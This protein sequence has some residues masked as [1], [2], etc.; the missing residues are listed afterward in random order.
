MSISGT[1][2]D[3]INL[4]I[5]KIIDGKSCL[6]WDDIID[7]KIINVVGYG[8]FEIYIN[9]KSDQNT[10]K[11]VVGYSLETELTQ[12]PLYDLHINDDDYFNYG[13]Q[14]ESNLDSYGNIKPIKLYNPSDPDHSLLHL[15]L[16]D[17]ACHWTLGVVPQYI[18]VTNNGRQE[19]ELATSFQRTFTI[20]GQNIYD[21]LVSD[22]ANEANLIYIFDTY[23]RRI[24][25]Y[26]RYAIGEDTNVF[27]NTRNLAE[28]IS[29]DDNADSVKNC[30][31]VVGGDDVVT[32]Y[33]AAINLTG[34]YIWGFHNFQ[35][36]DMPDG[37][38]N[39]IKSYQELKNEISDEYYG[40]Y[41]VLNKLLSDGQ[42]TDTI[43]TFD[44][45]VNSFTSLP[46][47]SGKTGHYY[48]INDTNK[49]YVSNGTS[50]VVCG[51]FTRLCSAYDYLSY[52][53]NSMMPNVSLKTTSAQEQAS[54][55]EREFVN[56]Q[57]AVNNLS[58]HSTASFT[59]VTNN[60]VA[61]CK[62]IIDNRY[63]VE[64]IDDIT[65]NYPRYSGNT[66]TGKIHIYRTADKN[67]TRTITLS[68]RINDDELNF[69]KQKIL[70]AVA[71]NEMAEVDQDV[72]AYTTSADYGKLV[73]YFQKYCLNRLKSFYDG[74]ETCLSILMSFQSSAKNSSA[75]NTI[76]TTY[77][78]RRDAVYEVY[79]IREGEVE[80]Q[81]Q[82]IDVIESE[83]NVIQ[84]QV[85]FKSYLDN[86]DPSYWRVF[87]SYRREDTY[88][89]DNYVSDGLT[90]GQILAK[91]K[92]LL[93]Y[94]AYQLSMVCQ[95]Q[96]TCSI[97]LSNL[98]IMDEFKP[99]WDKFQIYN[100]IRI[101][102]D[103]E[104]L[105]LRLAQVDVD[106]DAIEQLK[107]TFAENI[108]G[109][110]NIASDLS[111]IIK[112]TGFMASSY[113]SI[114]QQSS[115]GNKAF[116]Q[117]GKWIA[118][119]LNAAKTTIA[120]SD[121]NEV[122]FGSYGINLKDMTEEGNYGDFQTRLIGQGL[123]YTQDGWKTV[124]LA[125]GTI[126]IDGK[127]TSG[128]IAENLIGRLVACETLYLTNEKRSFLLSGD[129]A[130]FTD[131]TIDYQDK[132]GNRVKI[133]GTSDR[134][135]SISHNGNEVLYFNNVSNKMV[136][137]GTLQGCDGDFSGTLNACNMSASTITGST[138]NGNTINGN[139]ITGNTISSNNLIGNTITGGSIKIGN[140]F[141]VDTNGNMT[142]VDGTFTGTIK[143]GTAI[144]SPS[145]NGG[146]INGT[147][148]N[149][150]NNFIVDSSGNVT[151]NSG[152]FKG[153]IHA[154][155]GYFK[156]DLTGCSG[157][158]SDKVIGADVQAKTF[159]LWNP[160]SGKY[161][162]V[163]TAKNKTSWVYNNSG[164]NNPNVS[165]VCAN[166]LGT[167][168]FRDGYGKACID[169]NTLY[170]DNIY[171]QFALG[172]SSGTNGMRVYQMNGS[173]DNHGIPSAGWVKNFERIK[174]ISI[175]ENDYR[176]ANSNYT[177]EIILRF[178]ANGK[179][180]D[181]ER[182]VDVPSVEYVQQY[183]QGYVDAH[184]GTSSDQRL[185]D[186][187]RDLTD[188]SDAYMK[189]RPVSY[190]YKN[191]LYSYKTPAIEFGL[192]ADKVADLFPCEK[193]SVAWKSKKVLDEERVYC[194]DYAYRIDYKS[195]GIMTVQMVQKHEKM[196]QKLK[197]TEMNNKNII[198]SLQGENAILKQHLKRLEDLVYAAG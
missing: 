198:L 25:I 77:R 56:T 33:L 177:S 182:Q 185:K 156:G 52:L 194:P 14:D 93:D 152:V 122:T 183:V 70:K 61:Y 29:I 164:Y 27:I 46:S 102:N 141:S 73:S 178:G 150:N 140:K 105:K 175:G 71:K 130:K 81:K 4:N 172:T 39:A 124:S 11:E 118:D 123:Y 5:Y 106:F 15:L 42:S 133:G 145:I 157:I 181:H 45:N 57:V 23:N 62:V 50:W 30:L 154:D 38:V 31:R 58:I 109:N 1:K 43:L 171:L 135:F 40:G 97:T 51:V 10:L 98:L 117:V 126:Y 195:I 92:E 191:G 64:S 153:T 120:N 7:L 168:M 128:I 32:N 69:A 142:A 6:F 3:T 53:T 173:V 78:L 143:A 176:H 147:S 44:G 131:I 72:L 80:R 116:N 83:K 108:S 35:Y 180:K 87:N 2:F 129:T 144:Y 18:T 161:E 132:N 125:L 91:C 187:V 100:Y 167:E 59:G 66:W 54:R 189:L 75:F 113:N 63:T 96:R 104:I 28:N 159:S 190:R 138:I 186:N 68:V 41:D 48:H 85:D 148:I 179:A 165:G 111:D 169:T 86:I 170:V 160:N 99:F 16:M 196:L 74:Y 76:Y 60:V 162:T 17:K 139:T 49:Y 36:K 12:I 89:N 37:L 136:M 13:A 115:Q 103:G 158:F 166:I 151:A 193:Y 9:K 101:A 84:S 79:K 94:A 34:N 82:L 184:S 110:G 121:N 22:L 119:G 19:K 146:S 155:S 95:L 55:I 21:F 107:V 88:Q 163:I 20:D 112:Q 67:D 192:E 127:R 197:E 149:V 188:I 134:I 24:N 90:D 174:N 8:K 137:T 114:K 65:N 26:D 47:A